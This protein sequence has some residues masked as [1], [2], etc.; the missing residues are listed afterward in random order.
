MV[1]SGIHWK[2][3]R[4]CNFF[5]KTFMDYVLEEATKGRQRNRFGYELN[6]YF[7][8]IASENGKEN[9]DEAYIKLQER[10]LNEVEIL[11]DNNI[12]KYIFYRIKNS[13]KL[14]DAGYELNIEKAATE[15]NYYS[16]MPLIHTSNTL[17]MLITRFEEFMSNFLTELYTLYPEKYLDQQQIRFSELVD[18]GIDDIRKKI[19]LREVDEKMRASY[20]DWF[21]LLQEHG[22]RFDSCKNELEKLKEIYARRNI[23]IHNAG[24]VN[25]TYIKAVPESGLK[26]GEVAFIYNE[27]LQK[28]FDTIKIIIYKIM[29]EATRIIKNDKAKYLEAIFDMAFLELL[30]ENYSISTS[31]FNELM[32]SKVSNTEIKTMSMINRWIAEI[33]LHGVESVNAD[34][35]EFDTSILEEIYVLAK[36]LLLENYE[37]ATKTIEEMVKRDT[38]SVD[39]IEKWPLFKRFR[40]SIYYE[41]FKK[42]NPELFAVSSFE[43]NP[44]NDS[45]TEELQG[46]SDLPQIK[47]D[48]QI[49]LF[50][51]DC[52]KNEALAGIY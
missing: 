34:I 30:A 5:M 28:A 44:D 25:E 11:N 35:E 50:E 6:R 39:M 4:L 14:S 52:A 13:K 42:Q 40:N 47:D 22:M 36:E 16:D 18:K 10:V 43:L 38:I 12:D 33:E 7:D 19:V 26:E 9:T 2:E 48:G 45:I 29:I 20:M 15:Y 27:Y 49:A 51:G 46:I 21:K 23:I 8:Y 1:Y 37:S 31:V 17:V 41:D 3:Y 32:C 24:R